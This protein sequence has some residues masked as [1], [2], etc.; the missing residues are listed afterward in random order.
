MCFYITA[1]LPKEANIEEL[2]SLFDK[3]NMAFV[4]INN[5]YVISQL[6]PN[7]LYFR[8]TKNYCDCDTILGMNNTSIEYDKLLKSKKVKKL[9]KKNWS[10]EQIDKWIKKKIK[11]IKPHKITTKSSAE[12]EQETNNWI[13]FI[14]EILKIDS[15]KRLGILKHWYTQSLSIEKISVRKSNRIK[16]TELSSELLHKFEE[17]VLYEFYPIFK[18]K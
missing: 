12:V 18:Y 17:D 13:N 14:R 11:T 7:E 16:I 4:P 3:F 2:K 10:N 1:T 9:K 5:E 8:A 6:R 15:I